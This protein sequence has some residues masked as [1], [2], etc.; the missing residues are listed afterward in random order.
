MAESTQLV[1]KHKEVVEALIKHHG[2]HDGVWGLF[3]RF[4][5]SAMNVGTSEADLMPAA[6][7]PVVEI[8]LQKFENE[9]NIAVDA[10]RVNPA[11]AGIKQ[12]A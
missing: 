7:I 5:I 1:F 4:G 2:L 10:G 11:K 12:P 8:G 3:V 6:V 9:N